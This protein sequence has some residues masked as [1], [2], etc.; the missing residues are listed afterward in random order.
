[1]VALGG[2]GRREGEG[3]EESVSNSS[4]D[5]IRTWIALESGRSPIS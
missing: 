5:C 1:M 3:F 4:A 2:C